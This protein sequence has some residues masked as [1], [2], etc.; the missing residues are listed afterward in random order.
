M[1]RCLVDTN[2]LLWAC[3]AP[4]RLTV[5]AAAAYL[6]ADELFYSL[7]SPWEIGLKFSRG[8]FRELNVPTDW[9]QT[10]IGSL[11]H[12]VY[13]L[14]SVEISHCRRIENL[15]FHHEDP[16]ERMLNAQARV[17]NLTVIGSDEMF[18]AY[19]VKRIW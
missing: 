2:V 1:S 17:E 11:R 10:L 15:P 19:W 18:D 5:K 9:E 13:K 16:F 3:Y 12:E 4:A 7:L 14:I 6:A 8:A